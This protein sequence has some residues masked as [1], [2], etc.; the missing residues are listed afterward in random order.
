[1]TSVMCT[2]CGV[3]EAFYLRSYS[4]EKLCA[5]CFLESIEDRVRATISKYSMFKF[6]DRIA[7]A[8]SGGKDSLSLLHILARIERDFPLASLCAITVD[9]GIAGYRDEAIE[10]ASENCRELRVEHFIISFKEL[11]GFT[12]D[13]I[14]ERLKASKSGM[15]PCSYCGVLRRKALNVLAMKVGATKIATAHNLD[16][17]IQTF[18]LNIIHG[19]ILRIPRT[20]PTFD[21]EE[22]GLVPRVKPLCEI[23]EKEV[24]LYAYLKGIRFQENPCPYAGEALRNDIRNTLN[25]LEEKHPGTKYKIYRSAEKVRE[26]MRDKVPR[27]TLKKCQLCGEPTVGDICRACSLLKNIKML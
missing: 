10:I 8:V 12:L 22:P 21:E 9:E 3:R 20:S 15:T 14:V 24:T 18:M 16:D 27:I 2:V 17:E 26:A 11:Y 7:V 23:L 4:G 5:K 6:N 13:E 19:D 1:M 25:R